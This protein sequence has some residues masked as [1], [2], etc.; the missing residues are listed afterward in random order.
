MLARRTYYLISTILLNRRTI[1][2]HY[3]MVLFRVCDH[4]Y[5]SLS[6]LVHVLKREPNVQL[7]E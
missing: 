3:R 1:F 5:L 2:V 7:F 6:M 4:H